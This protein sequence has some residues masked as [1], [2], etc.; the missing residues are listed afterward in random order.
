LEETT[1]A[2]RELTGISTNR[3][4]LDSIARNFI[5]QTFY[6]KVDIGHR[7]EEILI[8]PVCKADIELENEIAVCD[9]GHR[10]PIICKIPILLTEALL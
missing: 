2:L 7:I 1:R 10:F 5:R 3:K 4:T 9:V 8:C 6:N